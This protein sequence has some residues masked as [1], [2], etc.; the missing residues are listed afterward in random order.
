LLVL[1]AAAVVAGRA[2]AKLCGDDV[3]GSDVPCACGDV[4]VSDLVLGDDPVVG[5]AC[6]SDGLVVRAP[7]AARSLVI[8]LAGKTVR[9]TGRGIGLWI[10]NG[11]PGGARVVSSGG[12]AT[13][14]NFR[15]GVVAHGPDSLAWL[16]S[17]HAVHSDR[18]G[19]QIGAGGWWQLRNS[20]ARTSG[21][22]GFM[23]T[24]NGFQVSGTRTADSGDDGYAVTGWGGFLTDIASERS[25]K[26]GLYLMG[27]GH[28]V[29]G[30]TLDGSAKH[31]GRVMGWRLQ[32]HNC[33][34]TGNGGDGLSGMVAWGHFSGNRAVDNAGEGVFVGGTEVFDE[35]GNSGEGNRGDK[36]SGPAVQC[37]LG[38]EPCRP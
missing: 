8:D 24:G 1:L 3:A 36:R 38:G 19:F 4:V 28:F 13:I 14:E 21:R 23:L 16:D 26:L 32:V 20:E 34:A 37:A 2:D 5:A 30:C 22:H 25:G 31:G 12:P 7:G 11:G 35:G 29:A 15:D 9:G 6:A 10:L 17:V 27:M 18:D 33:V